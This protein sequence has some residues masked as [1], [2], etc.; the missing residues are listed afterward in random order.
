MVTNRA[1]QKLAE[2][3]TFLMLA[4]SVGCQRYVE[5]GTHLG[6][7]AETAYEL[8]AP[9]GCQ[10]LSIDISYWPRP[11]LPPGVHYLI[12]DGHDEATVARAIEIL[13]GPPDVV[14]ID[15]DHSYQAVVADYL[16]WSPHAQK[17]IGFHDIYMAGVGTL[18]REL[19]LKQR[20][21]ELVSNDCVHAREW[22]QRCGWYPTDTYTTA[23]IGV[24]FKD[25]VF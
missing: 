12:G 6:G 25:A 3:Y 1:D 15:G 16:A 7:S 18:W 21:L 2:I 5:I 24:I 10:V 17:L 19:M 8:L 11:Y 4:K 20:T 23:G 22:E 9:G 14:F 13:G